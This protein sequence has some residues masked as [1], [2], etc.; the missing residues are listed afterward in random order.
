MAAMH[1]IRRLDVYDGASYIGGEGGRPP[2][3]WVLEMMALQNK[4]YWTKSD[5]EL[6]YIIKDAGEASMAMMGWNYEA[7]AKY[8]DQ[9]NDASSV[10]YAR[11]QKLTKAA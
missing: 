5:A 7:E 8:L 10:L 9:I 11:K 3:N 1:R 4:S 2:E 6:R